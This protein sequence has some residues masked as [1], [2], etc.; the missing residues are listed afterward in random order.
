MNRP[1]QLRAYMN[2]YLVGTLQQTASGGL[3]FH[4]DREWL[5][6]SVARP[7]SLSLPLTTQ[8]YRGSTVI[9]FFD[10]LL[11]EAAPIRTRIRDLLSASSTGTFDLLN[12]VG[13]DCVGALQLLPPNRKPDDTQRSKP[14][15]ET[16]IAQRLRNI[17]TDPMGMR[18]EEDFRISL[19]GVQ[20]KTALLRQESQWHL[21][22]GSTPTSHIYKLQ[23][24]QQDAFD[25]DLSQSVENEFLCSR[26]L[27]SFGLP[28]AGSEIADFDGIRALIVERFDRKL[29]NATGRLLRL[30]QEDLC[31]ALGLPASRKYQQFGGPDMS[32]IMDFLLSSENAAEDRR[33]FMKT[34]LLFWML[35]AIDGHAKNYSIFLRYQGR[36]RLAPLYDVISVYPVASANFP[37][38]KWKMA[39]SVR[40]KKRNH[41]R[42]YRIAPRHWLHTAKFCR[43]DEREMK[44]TLEEVA[45][46]CD[47]ALQMA[48]TRLP[49]GFPDAVVESIVGGV[50]TARERLTVHW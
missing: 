10:N 38:Q 20:S 31:Q 22:L 50:R 13:G 32:R 43:Y 1:S 26:I 2:G 19:A 5:D 12:A 45:D 46:T 33:N 37:R 9:D 36:Y 29:D 18:K 17:R 27:R 30:P 7:I 25:F 48:T 6:S 28:A 44:G 21:P 49:A 39:L 42:W 23:I 4:Y 3:E 8:T 47:D 35:A 14:L 11:P 41:Y 15:S 34:Q 16:E 24:G 40:G